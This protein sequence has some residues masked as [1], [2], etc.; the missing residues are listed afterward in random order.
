MF[1]L[2]RQFEVMSLRLNAGSQ[3][4][5]PLF[6][7]FVNG[8]LQLCPHNDEALLHSSM[9]RIAVWKTH[10]CCLVDALDPEFCSQLD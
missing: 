1:H 5:T 4:W 2:I 9:S 7:T 8:M 10:S 6:N 3:P